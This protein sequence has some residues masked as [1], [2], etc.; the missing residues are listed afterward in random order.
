MKP[1]NKPTQT[2]HVQSHDWA[3]ENQQLRKELL[4]RE[5]RIEELEAMASTLNNQLSEKIDQI[6]DLMQKMISFM[7]KTEH[8]H[9]LG[10]VVS[11]HFRCGKGVKR[12]L[13]NGALPFNID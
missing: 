3:A 6:N 11:T 7:A 4:S 9:P 8:S 1:K 13:K 12:G 5:K 2:I 10:M